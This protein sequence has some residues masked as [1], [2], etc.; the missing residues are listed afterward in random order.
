M[1]HNINSDA[2]I[3]KIPSTE[4]P[5]AIRRVF[6]FLCCDYGFHEPVIE[7]TSLT[8]QLSYHANHVAVEVHVE[9]RE[10]IEVA[11][12]RL[13]NG[14]RPEGWQIDSSGRQF[15]TRLY[16]AAWH[17]KTPNPEFAVP[18]DSSAQ[19]ILNLWLQAWAEQLRLQFADVL[20]DSDE[21]FQELNSQRQ[22]T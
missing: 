16:E 7:Q 19:E 4:F 3:Q 13:S 2:W 17:R 1:K 15:M 9:F 18:P 6:D 5:S 8:L 12:V 14:K 11:L 20:T 21:L 10:S 22:Q